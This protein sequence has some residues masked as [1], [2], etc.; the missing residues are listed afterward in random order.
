[1]KQSIRTYSTLIDTLITD[2][3]EKEAAFRAVET[4]STVKK[5]SIWLKY[6]D[7]TCRLPNGA[8]PSAASRYILFGVVLR[9]LL[10]EEGRCRADVL[11]RADFSR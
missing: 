8:W 9:D 10:A 2:P 6:M 11:E 3:Q 4:S 1:M 7:Q 5:R